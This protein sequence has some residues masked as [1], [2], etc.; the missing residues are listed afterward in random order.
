MFM[1]KKTKEELEQSIK[2]H[3]AKGKKVIT[4]YTET[5]S[6]YEFDLEQNRVRRNNQTGNFEAMRKDDQWN[7]LVTIPEFVVGQSMQF[8]LVVREDGVVTMRTTSYVT[9]IEEV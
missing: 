4:V 8:A 6:V 2:R 1:T 5:G 3:P 7:D 9:K